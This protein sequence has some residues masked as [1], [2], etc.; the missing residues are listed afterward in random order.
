MIN[1]RFFLGL[2]PISHSETILQATNSAASIFSFLVVPLRK[3]LPSS[4]RD[5][6][7]F[8]LQRVTILFALNYLRGSRI[9][10]VF[11]SIIGL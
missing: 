4:F 11:N 7:G 8:L 1:I 5:F 9:V 6:K 10:F 2:N 3:L